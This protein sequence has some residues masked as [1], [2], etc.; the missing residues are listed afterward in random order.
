[1][2]SERTLKQW[3]KDALVIF[4]DEALEIYHNT[5]PALVKVYRAQRAQILRM[6]QELLDLKLTQKGKS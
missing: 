5:T 2:I 1:M 6:T 4:D 3:R